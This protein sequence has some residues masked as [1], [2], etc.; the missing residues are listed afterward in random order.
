MFQIKL[1]DENSG[2]IS[3]MPYYEIDYT[4]LTGR[5]LTLGK[6]KVSWDPAEGNDI[7]YIVI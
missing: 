3:L 1:L 2:N 4:F 5:N 7:S 6:R